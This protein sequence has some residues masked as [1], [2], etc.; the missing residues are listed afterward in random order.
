M[1]R[2][3]LRSSSGH[4]H[5]MQAPDLF[6]A[7]K[8]PSPVSPRF[9]AQLVARHPLVLLGTLWLV[10]VCLSALAYH[11]LM[12]NDSATVEP[13]P[14]RSA[15]QPTPRAEPRSTLPVNPMPESGNL[16]M[17][18]G[19]WGLAS[20][21]GLSSLGCYV[22]S[23][24]TKAVRRRKPARSLSPQRPVLKPATTGPK[25][26]APYKT[27]RDAVIVK[28][29]RAVSELDLFGDD[30]WEG[31]VLEAWVLETPSAETLPAETSAPAP[32]YVLPP[33]LGTSTTRRGESDPSLPPPHDPLSPPAPPAMPAHPTTVVPEDEAHPL[34]WPEES[35]AHSLDLRQRRS[36][37]SLM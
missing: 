6:S 7:A 15:V 13:A 10:M 27:E 11:R 4:P 28:G 26:L 5:A 18:V 34:D 2:Q 22:I 29:A 19:L 32:S 25:R 33:R 30:S 1:V 31:E 12:V 37:S 9:W 14:A 16:G 17:Q 20:L 24:Q 23:Q 35:L 8:Q 36:L 21:V 3:P